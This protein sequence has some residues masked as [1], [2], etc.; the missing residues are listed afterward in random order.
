[1]DKHKIIIIG[2]GPTG[3]C[4]AFRLQELDET[5]FKLYEMRDYVG[6]LATT[7]TDPQGFLWDIGGHVQF[8]HYKYFDDLMQSLLPHGWLQHQRESWVWMFNRFIPYPLQN[9]IHRLPKDV[10]WECLEGMIDLYQT[11][12]GRG[13][14]NFEEWILRTAGKG[15]EKYFMYPYNRKVWAHSPRYMNSVWVG[16]RV[17]VTDLKRVIKN[18]LN[19]TDDV[20]WGP[21]NTFQFPKQ[22]GTGAIWKALGARLEPERVALKQEVRR[23]NTGRHQVELA[24]GQT[25]QYEYLINTMP[26]DK[27]V[28]RSDLSNEVKQAAKL[29]EHSTTHIVG[30]GLAGRPKAELQPKC[31]MY[32]PEDNCPFYRVTLFSKYSPA[33]V[34]DPGKQ[35]S[36]MAEVAASRYKPVNP[37]TV[38]QEVIQGLINTKLIKPSDKI[39]SRWHH[40]ETYGYPVPTIE[41]D[42]ALA[43]IQPELMKRH[44]LSRGRFGMWKY[45]VSNQDHSCMQGVEAV[46][47]IIHGVPE[48]T[49]WY[50][51][52]V[53]GP[54]P[55]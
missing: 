6:G 18:I 36:L 20:S 29:L 16:E 15:V 9:N 21:N 48:M 25:A 27:F 8:S 47:Y 54:R 5:D 40:V 38:V 3:L 39:V 33:N 34:P 42:G 35:W 51:N 11:Q 22:G 46:Y 55:Y 49:A 41:R 28:A 23:I 53:N 12:P 24:N 45:E 43:I 14:K 37:E 10:M 50:P 13:P 4:A 1:M 26:L 30:I 52:I 19:H 44:I 17:A 32:F 2:A 31:W 7:F